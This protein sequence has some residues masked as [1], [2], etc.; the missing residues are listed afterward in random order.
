MRNAVSLGSKFESERPDV[1]VLV[2]N[3]NTAHLLDRMFSAL[4]A[5]RGSLD[6]QV[7]VVDNASRDESVEMLRKRYKNA[8]VIENTS[9]VGFG[10][11]NNQALPRVRGRYLL[12]LNTD[13]FV[14]PETLPSTVAFMD[15]H[16]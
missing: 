8:E 7:I 5:G 6:L 16:P 1:T 12:L 9:N 3:Y 13:A 14:S 2:V 4:E 11:A 10:R 15:A